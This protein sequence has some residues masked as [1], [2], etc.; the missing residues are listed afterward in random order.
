MIEHDIREKQFS[1]FKVIGWKIGPRREIGKRA[2]VRA[3]SD[4]LDYGIQVDIPEVQW[5]RD[6]SGAL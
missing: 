2:E 4:S 1:D 3:Q 5:E 6:G